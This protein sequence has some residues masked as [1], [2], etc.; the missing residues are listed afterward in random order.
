MFALQAVSPQSGP[1]GS[2]LG[3]LGV[4]LVVGFFLYLYLGIALMLIA[5]RSNTSYSGLAFL[6]IGNLF[7][8]CR[9]GRRPGWWVLLLLLPVINVAVFAMIWMSIAE[10]RGKPVW[11]GA[12]AAVP[13]V[14]LIV[15][16][17]FAIGKTQ[18]PGTVAARICTA[19]GTPI[20][21]LE[22]FCRNCGHAA[23]GPTLA[24]RTSTGKLALIGAITSVVVV[25]LVGGVV[26]VTL[27]R[28][29]SYTPPDRKP[30]AIPERLAGTMTEFPVDTDTKSDGRMEPGSVITQDLGAGGST[31]SSQ[32]VPQKWLPPGVTRARLP[33]VAGTMTS[34]AYRPRRRPG[35][36]TE[37]AVDQVY[38]H[39]LRALQNQVQQLVD[40]LARSVT[41][42]TGGSRTGVRV[43]SP[44]GVVYTGSR[45]QSPQIS[46]Y[47]L[48][49]QGSDIVIL[50]YGA[51]PAVRDATARLAG[52][53]GNGQGLNDAPTIQTTVWTLPRQPPTDFVLQS[54]N[55]LS[56]DELFSSA[57]F[58][59]AGNDQ[60][61]RELINKVRQFIPE[62]ITTAR[63]RDGSRRDWNVYVYDYESTRR[64]WNTWFFLRWTV[65][66]S[67][68]SVTVAGTDGL[69]IDTDQGRALVFQ[70]GPYLIAIQGPSGSDVPSLV[71]LANRF[72]V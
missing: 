18:V 2:I 4:L 58:Q 70:K 37:S 7:L 36:T 51:S 33:Q 22:S 67:G 21:G 39:V 15:P 55:T 25:A 29:L 69:Y 10:V 16:L 31:S 60:Q 32:Q 12:L 56:G 66:L 59:S 5:K 49:R 68:Q 43:Q 19:C 53:V 23:P 13:L 1:A 48:Q 35:A 72:Q 3:T 71:D 50:I 9:I 17:Y 14:A 26:W 40:E 47:V 24:R 41:Q 44:G 6:P 65:G 52:N 46:V 61:T 20:L 57:D 54:V 28:G 11:T 42:A 38:V 8:M 63:Y 30:P 45:I 27:F 62:R 34:A 64:A